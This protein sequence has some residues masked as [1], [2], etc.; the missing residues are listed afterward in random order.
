[1]R[2]LQ[3]GAGGR[4]TEILG[5]LRSPERG[6]L[7]RVVEQ[8]GGDDGRGNPPPRIRQSVE[9]PELEPAARADRREE[10]GEVVVEVVDRRIPEFVAVEDPARERQ[11]TGERDV[12]IDAVANEH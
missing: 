4:Q 12:P 8:Q 1:R 5:A 2:V 10:R 11:R 7:R 9:V 6:S 3:T